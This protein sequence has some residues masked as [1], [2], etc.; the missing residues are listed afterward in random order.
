MDPGTLADLRDVAK[1]A[2]LVIETRDEQGG[3][4]TVRTVATAVGVLLALSILALT[5]GLLRSDASRDLR[6]LNACGAT[7]RIR[8]SITATTS[9]VLAAVGV[10]LGT[11]AAYS[12]LVVG[13]W[14]DS[15]RLAKIPVGNLAVLLIGLP[16]LASAMAWVVGGNER[17]AP[18]HAGD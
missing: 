18:A 4:T 9:G 13:Y 8:R 14:P 16:V 12:V 11:M 10:G 17:T 6:T 2:G 7:R 3:L 15:D 5:I 1:E